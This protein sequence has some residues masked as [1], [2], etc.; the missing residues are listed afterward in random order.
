[1]LAETDDPKKLRQRVLRMVDVMLA[2]FRK[3]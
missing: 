1:M 2:A 3:T